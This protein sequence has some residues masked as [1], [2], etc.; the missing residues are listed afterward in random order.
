MMS[1]FT[2]EGLGGLVFLFVVAVTVIGGVIATIQ[3][4]CRGL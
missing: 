1:L 2:A 4:G 3:S